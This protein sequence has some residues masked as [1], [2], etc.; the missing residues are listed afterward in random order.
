MTATPE[1]PLI[2]SPAADPAVDSALEAAAAPETGQD[3][4][5][6][7]AMGDLDFE[8]LDTEGLAKFEAGDEA[9]IREM[10]KKHLPAEETPKPA[11]KPKAEEEPTGQET[12][13]EGDDK[14]TTPGGTIPSRVSIKH[15]PE[16]DRSLLMKALDLAR[17]G[18]PLTEAMREALG[19]TVEPAAAPASQTPAAQEKPAEA[20]APAFTATP[21]TSARVAELQSKLQ[22]L[23]AEY[24]EKQA[25]Y[26][27]TAAD[28]LEQM[29]DVKLDLRDA[30]R[31]AQTEVRQAQAFHA[32]VLASRE[33]AATAFAEDM[34]NPQFLDFAEAEITLAEIRRDPIMNSPDWPEKIAQLVKAK[35]FKE[36]VA[37]SAAPPETATRQPIPPAPASK[38]RLPGSPTGS[39][40]AAGAISPETAFTEISNLSADQIDAILLETEKAQRKAAR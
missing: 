38:V 12:D 16:G 35:Y 13:T 25:I 18:K 20:P 9:G 19:G 2:E 39:A 5:L 26:D 1:A 7:K 36:A 22:S 8:S 28:V 15:I 24:K 11:D 37:Q 34:K 4:D 21:E 14:Q 3:I 33:R 29:Q 23:Q 6:D 27:P 32:S 10:L 30:A 31:D 17:A 40:F